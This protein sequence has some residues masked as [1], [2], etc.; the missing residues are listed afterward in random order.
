MNFALI[1]SGG[2]GSRMR[3]DGFPKQYIEVK[4]KPILLYTLEKFQ[5][6]PAID[7]LVIVADPT[8]QEQISAWMAQSG[9]SKF[10]AFANPGESRQESI[11]SGLSACMELSQSEADGVIIHDGVRPLVSHGLITAC[12]DALA[13]YD[14]SMPVLPV[15]DTT[16]LSQDGKHI[17]GLLDRST[18]FS[19]QSP[20]AFRLHPYYRINQASSKQELAATRGTTEIAYRHN[21]NIR[22]IPGEYGNF[23]LTTPTDLDRFRAL[24]EEN[25]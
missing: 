9:I 1:L 6:C 3:S 5:T 7:K 19:G 13:E 16:Y 23:K 22:L 11:F 20:E 21:F 12:L 18:L 14:G 17:S 2:V 15:T 24:L 10:A 4:D 8:W 25:K